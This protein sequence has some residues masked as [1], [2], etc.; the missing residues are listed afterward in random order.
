MDIRQMSNEYMIDLS[1]EKLTD[2]T[3]RAFAGQIDEAG[4][5]SM[6]AAQS[7]SQYPSLAEQIAKGVTPGDYFDPYK[8]QISKYTDTPENQ[9]D[10]NSATWRKIVSYATPD[11]KVR[12]MTLDES[13]KYIRSTDE[14]AGS[15]TGQ[16]ELASYQ[17]EM[18]KM[19]GV[20]R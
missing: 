15:S 5:R 8:K 2:L 12:P 16:R 17:V 1:D 3:R 7:A 20:R 13:I 14:F 10:L 18:Q 19:F 4:L 9:I 6:F 11:G